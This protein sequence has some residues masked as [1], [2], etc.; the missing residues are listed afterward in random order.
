MSS[1][2]DL[3]AIV[4]ASKAALEASQEAY[5]LAL[6]RYKK[7]KKA[8]DDSDA[9]SV[10]SVETSKKSKKDKPKREPGAWPLYTK[11][12]ISARAEEY[13]TF[14]AN[15]ELVKGNKKGVAPLFA[16]VMAF[17]HEEEF[18]DFYRE[19]AG[20]EAPARKTPS[21]ETMAM[22]DADAAPSAAKPTPKEKKEKKAKK[23]ATPPPSDDEKSDAESVVSAKPAPKASAASAAAVA[24]ASDSEVEEELKPKTIKGV[25]YLMTPTGLAW[26][27]NK[28][29][30]R[31]DWAGKYDAKTGRID[32]SAEEPEVE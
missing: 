9:S 13:A 15:F 31:G 12:I 17:V 27:I 1:V 8:A 5:D 28:D 25:R 11:H 23:V 7:A 26:K 21:E 22:L 14:C 18:K 6:K 29:G 24:A 16:S 19:K 30:S 20:K 32:D 10:S 4:K 2:K 3:K